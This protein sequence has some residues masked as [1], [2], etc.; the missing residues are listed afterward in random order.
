MREHLKLSGDFMDCVGEFEVQRVPHGPAARIK[1]E[2]MVTYMSVDIR[3]AVK[4][5]ARNL[6]GLGSDYGVRLELP[7]HLKST[8]K[9]LQAVSFELKTKFPLSRRNVLFDDEA[10]DL[11]LD[12]TAGEDKPWRRITSKQ[13]MDRKKNK[14]VTN[15]P[16]SVGFGLSDGELDRILDTPSGDCEDERA[17]EDHQ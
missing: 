9:T 2:A 15:G 16:Q 11:V 3:D 7:N 5:A 10:M 12:F 13:A 17:S 14:S 8:M 1:H 6:A 4:G